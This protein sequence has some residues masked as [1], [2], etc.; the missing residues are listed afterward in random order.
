MYEIIINYCNNIKEGKIYIEPNKLNI[1]YGI[2][3]TGKT[4]VARAIKLSGNNNEL[5]TL[6]SFFT[7]APASVSVKPIFNK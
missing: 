1:K 6:K 7:D 2:N 3:G 5:Q 4:T